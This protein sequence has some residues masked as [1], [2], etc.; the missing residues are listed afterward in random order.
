MILEE[1]GLSKY[2]AE[3][4]TEPETASADENQM[5]T[6]EQ[7]NLGQTN[8]NHTKAPSTKGLPSLTGQG[9]SKF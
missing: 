4:S 6:Q 7:N 1:A 2:I 8:P 3:M 5:F 9:S